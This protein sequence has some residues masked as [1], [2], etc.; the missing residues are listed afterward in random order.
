MN[1]RP[2]AETPELGCLVRQHAIQRDTGPSE[3]RHDRR[4]RRHRLH[5]YAAAGVLAA[6]PRR[7]PRPPRDPEDPLM[8]VA[9][10]EIDGTEDR[11]L[12]ARAVGE[13]MTV[14]DDGDE[15]AR[16]APGLYI[17]TTESGREYL[18]D[19]SLPACECPD[20]QYRGRMCKHIR[21]VQFATGVREI[22]ARLSE[23]DVDAQLGMHVDD[24]QE[25]DGKT[26]NERTK[27]TRS[28]PAD[29][30]GGDTTGV[31]DL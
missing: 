18:V 27:P 3:F 21:R 30:G 7:R 6:L 16:R 14:L 22:P 13:Y 15:R 4:S 2:G 9:T 12:D 26:D 29:F 28:E 31:Q 23:G 24:V 8:A 1:E 11:E 20:F 25:T 10:T 5:L 17:V 19:V